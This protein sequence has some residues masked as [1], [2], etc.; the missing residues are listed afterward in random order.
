MDRASAVV[1]RPVLLCPPLP[2]PPIIAPRFLS[3]SFGKL[4]FNHRP[5]LSWYHGA[6]PLSHR[7]ARLPLCPEPTLSRVE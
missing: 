2:K 5:M 4:R 7:F 1:D 6:L 3:K